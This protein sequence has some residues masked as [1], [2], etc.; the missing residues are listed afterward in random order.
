LNN[1]EFRNQA[2]ETASSRYQKLFDDSQIR[3]HAC[4]QTWRR[5]IALRT[6]LFLVAAGFLGAG[7]LRIT[8][9]SSVVAVGFAFAAGFILVAYFH[10][11]LNERLR[12]IQIETQLY[13]RLLA[14]MLRDWEKLPEIDL[15]GL[16][17]TVIDTAEDLD[18]IKGRSLIRWVS[19]AGTKTGI[20][21]LAEQLTSFADAS[22]LK[23]RQ[24]ASMELLPMQEPRR[25]TLLHLWTLGATSGSLE[26]FATWV[27]QPFHQPSWLRSLSIAGPIC[28]LFGVAILAADINATG[29][30][31]LVG[32]ALMV[33][34]ALI[35][36][37]LVI[38][39][40]G[41]IHN[42]FKSVDSH[43]DLEAVCKELKIAFNAAHPNSELLKELFVSLADSNNSRA[44]I[45]A[46]HKLGWPMSLA[47]MRLQP[48][49]YIPFLILQLVILWDFRIINWLDRWRVRHADDVQNWLTSIGN[50]EAILSAV[51]IAE[52]YP[53]WTFP[54]TDTPSGILSQANSVGHPLLQDE[55]RV[56]NDLTIQESHP[57]LL[58]TGSN[59]AGK[60]TLMR[61][62]GVNIALSRIGAPVCATS[63][64]C[65]PLELATSI[66]VRDSLADGV[67]FFMAELLRLKK[68]V[69]YVATNKTDLNRR[70]LVILDEILQGTN[71]RERQ[72]AVSHIIQKLLRFEPLLMVSTHDLQLADMDGFTNKSQI[73]HFREHFIEQ[74]GK[75]QMRF[76]YQLYP[77]VA[78][79]TNALKL[80]DLVGLN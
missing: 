62:L 39:F 70:S 11:V 53:N 3:L 14:R 33:I 76:D 34:G 25:K 43:R 52:E 6:I 26:N 50:L 27:S 41:P 29:I 56:C 12:R 7:Y 78:P 66:R 46:L 80:L 69:D 60:S 54:L 45:A 37:A 22:T 31:L 68:V 13:R 20:E 74:D 35:N 9:S 10:E 40:V 61:T 51:S 44:A 55:S 75:S 49:L 18:L 1:S 4:Q 8:N 65:Q 42:V 15:P 73:I 30:Q 64:A 79:T 47:G 57:V 67:S 59:M 24:E 19:L 21:T 71:S 36:L 28:L 38:G 16:D 17:Q 2:T 72:I 77:G 48:L 63:F 5:L 58:I 23:K 32:F